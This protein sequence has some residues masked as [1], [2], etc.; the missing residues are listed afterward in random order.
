MSQQSE[1]G[2]PPSWRAQHKFPI[3]SAALAA[4]VAGSL[5]AYVG[6]QSGAGV[7]AALAFGLVVLGMA[8]TVW[9]S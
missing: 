4:I 5:G 8:A 3:Q 6:L 2:R 1:Q 7:L 9:V